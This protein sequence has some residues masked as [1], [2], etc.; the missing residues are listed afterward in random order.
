MGYASADAGARG[1]HRLGSRSGQYADPSFVVLDANPTPGGAWSHRWDSLTMATINHIADLP[2]LHAPEYEPTTRAN[3]YVPAYFAEFEDKYDLP[4][5]RPVRVLRV[6]EESGRPV[7]RPGARTAGSVADAQLA[8]NRAAHAAAVATAAD[9]QPPREWNAA[10]ASSV[11]GRLRVETTAGTW[12]ARYVINA[13]GTWTRP[14]I[15]YYPGVE[16][17]AGKQYHTANYRDKEDFYG[18]V[19]SL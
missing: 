7:A 1:A 5:F 8:Q 6:E 2:G 10:P 18:R 3:I 4:I 14:F 19:C 11:R 17:F 16:L 9:G 13:T 12:L 15:P